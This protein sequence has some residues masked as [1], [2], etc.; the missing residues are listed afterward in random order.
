LTHHYVHCTSV[1]TA[2][3]AHLPAPSAP[4]AHPSSMPL[5]LM[6]PGTKLLMPTLPSS[7]TMAAAFACYLANAA[8]HL[9][10]AQLMYVPLCVLLQ[11]VRLLLSQALHSLMH[12]IMSQIHTCCWWFCRVLLSATGQDPLRLLT[13]Q[14]SCV[15]W[16]PAQPLL[17]PP[18]PCLA[19]PAASSELCCHKGLKVG[20]RPP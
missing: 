2:E 10:Q 18:S 16:P 15:C 14:L 5:T 9:R 13:E 19:D 6:H 17:P 20:I 7:C 3:P 4:T 8:V 1:Y 12:L 11:V